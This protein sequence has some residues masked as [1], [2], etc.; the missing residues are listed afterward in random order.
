MNPDATNETLPP[1]RKD[2]LGHADTL[3]L[4][5]IGVNPLMQETL[6][7]WDSGVRLK[8]SGKA[9]YLGQV[10]NEKLVQRFHTYS[11]WSATSIDDQHLAQLAESGDAQRVERLG[12]TF[13]G[14]TSSHFPDEQASEAVSP[15]RIAAHG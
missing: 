1:L 6:R 15:A 9:L 5:R 3:L 12:V 8:P 14:A 4:H 13:W 11:Y 7:L 10:S 2:Y